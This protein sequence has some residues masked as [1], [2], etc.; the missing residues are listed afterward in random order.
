M[1]L[2]LLTTES[3]ETLKALSLLSVVKGV[4]KLTHHPLV[5][6]KVPAP[7]REAL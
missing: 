6:T 4:A 1:G 5:T 3:T 2:Y 7:G